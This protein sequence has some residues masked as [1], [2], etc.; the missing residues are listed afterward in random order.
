MI[1]VGFF[2]LFLF[3]RTIWIPEYNN[4]LFFMLLQY[5]FKENPPEQLPDHFLIIIFILFYQFFYVLFICMEK[6]KK[7][8]IYLN[9]PQ[10]KRK[11]LLGFFLWAKS[12]LE[13]SWFDMSFLV[14]P[15][16][17]RHNII[18]KKTHSLYNKNSLNLCWPFL[19]HASNKKIFKL[20]QQQKNTIIK[21]KRIKH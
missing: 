1:F 21:V 6:L 15:S 3:S 18:R 2:F 13:I 10:K 20:D 14:F 9:S 17:Q 4:L 11:V 8:I 12:D 5:S 16:V 19:F 7:K